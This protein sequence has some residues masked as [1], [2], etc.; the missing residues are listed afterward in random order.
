MA[1]KCPCEQELQTGV[2][3]GFHHRERPREPGV[4]CRSS[5]ESPLPVSLVTWVTRPSRLHAAAQHLCPQP[6]RVQRGAYSGCLPGS[7]PSWG[8]LSLTGCGQVSSSQQGRTGGLEITL[9]GS[10]AHRALTAPENAF[11]RRGSEREHCPETGQG[12]ERPLTRWALWIRRPSPRQP[13][14]A[15]SA[16]TGPRTGWGTA[17]L[18]PH[19]HGCSTSTGTSHTRGEPESRPDTVVHQ[20]VVC[21]VSSGKPTC[22]RVEK[23][24]S[25]PMLCADTQWT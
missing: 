15:R 20:A 5:P 2:A 19:P 25:V 14:E 24:P 11:L 17:G 3:P 18:P 8:G 13:R 6:Q 21:M 1:Q 22:L 16:V 9:Y 7:A 12:P 23:S 10:R 4:A